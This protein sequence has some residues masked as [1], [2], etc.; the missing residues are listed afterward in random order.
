MFGYCPLIERT[1]A[2][3]TDCMDHKHCGLKTGNYELTKIQNIT[4]C[5]KPKKKRGRR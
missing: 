2:Y 4:T 1:C 3:A 5:P